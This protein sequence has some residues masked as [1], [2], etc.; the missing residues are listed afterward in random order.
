MLEIANECDDPGY[1]LPIL[2]PRHI[3][4]LIALAQEQKRDVQ[5]LLIGTSFSGGSLPTANVIRESDFILLHD[6][7]AGLME[8]TRKVRGYTPKPIVINQDSDASHRE[9]A[10]AAHVSYGSSK[11]DPEFF[12]KVKEVTGT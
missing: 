11:P 1:D 7:G 8:R 5:R 9:A 3:H 4:E 12:A 2:N 6:A 10:L